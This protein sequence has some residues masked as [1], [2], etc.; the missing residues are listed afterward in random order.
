MKGLISFVI[1]SVKGLIRLIFRMWKSPTATQLRNDISKNKYKP[2]LFRKMDWFTFCL[3]CGIAIFGFL[4]IFAATATATEEEVTGLGNIL[5]THTTYYVT[6]QMLWFAIGMVAMFA[7]AT[8]DYH[9]YGK[10]SQ[11]IYLLNILVLLIVMLA[12]NVGRGGMKAFF[13]WGSTSNV[14]GTSHGLQ[15]SEFGKIAII[16]ALANLFANRKEPIKNFHE[17]I[18]SAV[19]VVIPAFLVALQPDFGTMLVYFVIYMILLY[20]SGTSR[21][22]IWGVIAVIAILA[23]P[24]WFYMNTASDSFRLTRI[25]MWLKPERYPDDARQVIN[26]QIAIGTGGLFGKGMFSVGSFASLGFI[27]DDHTDFCF[28]IVCEAFG[29]LG[30]GLLVAA[31]GILLYRLFA[32][33]RQ[34]MDPLGRYI[35]VGVASMFLFHVLEN[36]CMI[37]GIL[38]VTGIPLPFISYGGSNCL[39]NMMALGLVMNVVMRSRQYQLSGHTNYTRSI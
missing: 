34:A 37:L 20:I 26:G 35:I 14:S 28:A 10:Y 11:I 27:P 16:I 21:K 12:A 29:L 6:F 30:G 23:I 38:P 8:L 2:G 24:L 17:L 1:R 4:S 39:T 15:P 25:L 33:S 13:S 19:F 9:L 36:V 31:F 32:L 18:P 3:V 7:V 5:S 22:L